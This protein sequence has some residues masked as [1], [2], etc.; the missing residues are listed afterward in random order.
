MKH[1]K[2]LA[3]RTLTEAMMNL[4]NMSAYETAQ[5]LEDQIKSM[6]VPQAPVQEERH[7]GGAGGVELTNS[8]IVRDAIEGKCPCCVIY[9]ALV[10]NAP[11][12]CGDEE[13]IYEFGVGAGYDML[14]QTMVAVADKIQAAMAAGELVPDEVFANRYGAFTQAGIAARKRLVAEDRAP[15]LDPVAKLMAELGAAALERRMKSL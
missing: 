5:L 6:L 2:A 13:F 15:E 7:E 4:G 9:H 11:L 12:P 14:Q 10:T 3:I 8:D 1:E